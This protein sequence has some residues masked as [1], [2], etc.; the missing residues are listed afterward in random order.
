M[1]PNQ[2]AAIWPVMKAFSEQRQVQFMDS[3]D[4]LESWVTTI[5]PNFEPDLKWRIKPE[6]FEAKFVILPSGFVQFYEKSVE[7]SRGSR[8]VTLREVEEK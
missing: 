8:I 3:R 2:A 5:D 6:L 4:S 1:T 7:Y